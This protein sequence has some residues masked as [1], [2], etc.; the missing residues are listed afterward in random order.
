MLED[1]NS[2]GTVQGARELPVTVANSLGSKF[3]NNMGGWLK[4]VVHV[5]SSSKGSNGMSSEPSEPSSVFHIE[6]NSKQRD[7]PQSSTEV[8]IDPHFYNAVVSLFVW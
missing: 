7:S 5:E 3:A 6:S 2:A 8:I 1:L 4:E